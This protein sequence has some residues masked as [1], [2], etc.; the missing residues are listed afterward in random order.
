MNSIADDAF[1]PHKTKPNRKR[2]AFS[3]SLFV[4]SVFDDFNNNEEATTSTCRGRL[5][6]IQFHFD[7]IPITNDPSPPFVKFVT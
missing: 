2:S 3:S 7:D 5:Y 4:V 1:L 6:E